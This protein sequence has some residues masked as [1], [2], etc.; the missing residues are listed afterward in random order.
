M[1]KTP[2]QTVLYFD[3]LIAENRNLERMCLIDLQH[4]HESIL[5]ATTR[6]VKPKFTRIVT[7]LCE[8][9]A[10]SRYSRG[11]LLRLRANSIVDDGACSIS[12]L[13]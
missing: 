3:W 7:S 4:L 13:I 11:T 2:R 1:D 5:P 8:R 6:T 10:L 12:S 9:K